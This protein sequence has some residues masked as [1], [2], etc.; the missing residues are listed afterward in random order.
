LVE[1]ASNTTRLRRRSWC[2][3]TRRWFLLHDSTL[4][5]YAHT[6]PRHWWS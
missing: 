2:T 6:W 4:E 3:A 1:V 5:V